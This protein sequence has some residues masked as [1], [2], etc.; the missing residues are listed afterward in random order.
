MPSHFVLGTLITHMCGQNKKLQS[1]KIQ[2]GQHMDQNIQAINIQTEVPFQGQAQATRHHG[3]FVVLWGLS[4]PVTPLL[5]EVR[6]YINRKM[7][8][9]PVVLPAVQRWI[10]FSSSF[11]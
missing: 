1:I 10:E 9:S 4:T 5:I 3:C 8:R 2:S 7:H 11:L 6:I